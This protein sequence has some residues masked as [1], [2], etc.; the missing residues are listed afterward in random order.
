MAKIELQ[1]AKEFVNMLRELPDSID[2]QVISQAVRSG[3]RELAKGIAAKAPSGE[4]E[5]S[6]KS[7]EYGRLRDNIEHYLLRRRR[8]NTRAA[9]VSTGDAFWGFIYEFGSRRQPA[10]PWWDSAV[11]SATPEAQ[12]AM[13]LYALS[14]LE[15]V[16]DKAI[17]KHGV[18]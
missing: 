12:D 4:G 13:A 6:P 16:V 10:R 8:K 17:T 9:I 3:A 7:R 18:Q 11:S 15:Q 14:K 2:R 5:Q 1:N